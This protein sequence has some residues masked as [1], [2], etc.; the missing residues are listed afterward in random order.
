MHGYMDANTLEKALDGNDNMAQ[1]GFDPG[2]TTKNALGGNNK[3]PHETREAIQ[4]H[5]VY[6]SIIRD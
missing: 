2:K 1:K 5:Y 3:K 4:R 6:K